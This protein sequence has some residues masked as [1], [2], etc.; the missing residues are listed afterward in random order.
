MAKRFKIV[1]LFAILVLV[2][3]VS[4]L[5][6]IELNIHIYEH[7]VENYLINELRYDQRDIA[8]V[9]GVY[10]FK[11]PEFYTVVVF[12]NEPYVEY[13]YFAHDGVLQ[14]EYQII[15]KEFNEVTKD[16]LKNYDPHGLMD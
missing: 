5:I 10:G 9:K 3:I 13:L 16:D 7:R 14:Y 6:Y 8:S 11:L 12:T 15:D 4:R 2:I 1:L